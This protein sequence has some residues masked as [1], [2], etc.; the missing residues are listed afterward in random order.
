VQ[1]GLCVPYSL[2]FKQL[3]SVA[4]MA[5]CGVFNATLTGVSMLV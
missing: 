5:F 1:L 4:V 3:A 2:Y